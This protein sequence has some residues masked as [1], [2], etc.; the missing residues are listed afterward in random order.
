MR[1]E[2]KIPDWSEGKPLT[3]EHVEADTPSQAILNVLANFAPSCP[4]TLCCVWE[5]KCA[6]CEEKQQ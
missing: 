4:T 3:V 2:V 1:Y 6:R 5:C